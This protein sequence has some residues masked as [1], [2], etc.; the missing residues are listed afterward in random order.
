MGESLSRG[1]AGGLSLARLRPTVPEHEVH[2][3]GHEDMH[4]VLLLAG[5][6][7]SDA[8]G[9]PAICNEPMLVFNPPGTEHRDRFRSR[10]GL[11]VVLT[12]A[13]PHFEVL[14]AGADGLSTARRM[15]PSALSLAL[16]WLRELA[17]WDD[18]S[19]LA[20]ESGMVEALASAR[21]P[22][23]PNHAPGLRRALERL[24][25]SGLAVPSVSELAAVAGLH[26]VH[27]ARVFRR[28]TGI[29]PA[30][31]LRRR[32]VHRCLPLLLAGQSLARSASALGFT[33]ESHLHRSFVRELGLTPGT[34]R[35]LALGRGEVARI[36]GRLMAGC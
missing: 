36:Q 14:A 28:A 1:D 32:R 25:E 16:Q 17:Q 3:H 31:Y 26:P 9:M 29:A 5:A 18:T 21:R 4:A 35:R 27:F 13:R 6:Y 2:R 12:L 11:F 30:E 20:V 22:A 33:D 8:E 24:D 34:F 19:G 10:D 7:V 23:L 15:P